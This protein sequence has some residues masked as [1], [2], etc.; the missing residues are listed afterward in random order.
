MAFII[1]ISVLVLIA[2][3]LGLPIATLLA[4][5]RAEREQTADH[6]A[7]DSRLRS[8]ERH[9]LKILARHSGGVRPGEKPDK[10][11]SPLAKE[12]QPET[13]QIVQSMLRQAKTN[14][15]IKIMSEG[16]S[17]LP[18]KESLKQPGLPK[19]QTAPKLSPEKKETVVQPG[20]DKPTI[21]PTA[22]ESKTKAV[23]P[24]KPVLVAKVVG[25]EEVCA[26][27]APPP[28]TASPIKPLPQRRQPVY[29]ASTPNVYQGPSDLEVRTKEVLQ[30]IWNWIVVGEEY[31]P[32]GVSMEYAIAKN[33]LLRIGA[34]IF[35]LGIGFFL[36]YSID[37]GWIG[38]EGRIALT[39]ITGL[40]MV[41]GGTFLL[42]GKKYDLFGQGLVGIG[43]AVLYFT[44]FAAMK[45]YEM[46]EQLPAFALMTLVTAVAC[47]I[48]VRF[49]TLLIALIG[50]IGGYATP[51]LLSTGVVDLTGLFT[52]LSILTAGVLAISYAKEW[53]LVRA[54]SLFGTWG[55]TLVALREA[56]PL[57]DAEFIQVIPF[58]VG[59]FVMFSTM[60]FLYNLI[61]QKESTLLEL[62]M[63]WGNAVT[64]FCIAYALFRIR[65][66]VPDSL[67][68]C[69]QFTFVTLGLALFYVVHIYYFLVK[70]VEDRVLLSSFF[71]I[72]S[73]ML[74][75]TV[76]ILISREWLAVSWAIQAL[77][78]LWVA[79][80]LDSRFLE[81]VA[82][83]L[84]TIVFC[85]FLG[86]LGRHFHPVTEKTALV[87][88]DFWMQLL[89]RLLTFGTMIGSF[90]GASWLLNH[91]QKSIESLRVQDENNWAMPMESRALSITMSVLCVCLGFVYLNFEF[92]RT[93]NYLD[94][95]LTAPAM[96]VLWIGLIG[97]LLM[98]YLHHKSDAL[99]VLLG[100][101]IVG[102]F[103]KFTFFDLMGWG[104]TKHFYYEA[105]SMKPAMI[106]LFDFGIII[107]MLAA[108]GRLL[109][110]SDSENG[111]QLSVISIVGAIGLLFTYTSLELN[112]ILYH[113]LPGSR[114]G[115]ISVLWSLYA[116]AF[117][118]IG[119]WK[120]VR[121]VRYAGLAL[122][123]IVTMKV[124]FVDLANAVK[125]YSI[126]FILLGIVLMCGSLVYMRCRQAF[127]I[128][129]EEEKK[130]KLTS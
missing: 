93:F 20:T 10:Q 5:L 39:T 13:E 107:A 66:G 46:I 70:K 51:I 65:F 33:W 97:F 124:L 32:E 125:A 9:A 75:I 23:P 68:C 88:H 21:I 108:V 89:E 76:P 29:S 113:C 83:V 120:N 80:K 86:D 90:F 115:G 52:Y 40:G 126:A 101:V 81:G 11:E 118:I 16:H 12:S 44:I 7:F 53:H 91:R 122:F 92:Y 73:F 114:M 43:V 45:Q 85:M 3:I 123:A 4:V 48:A 34:L 57:E 59:F 25:E 26:S 84:Y 31:R 128:E 49:N 42:G 74:T 72:A 27:D 50:V 117:I 54:V 35:V 15:G 17:K 116:L 67:A 24:Q 109:W 130:E 111:H 22:D 79:Q 129:E 78:M 102:L 87:P 41:T 77:V 38:P 19:Q 106:R 2:L 82:G 18:G 14:A 99:I 119:I 121:A 98:Q 104:I 105:C 37:Q 69:K 103:L 6:N 58:M 47:G 1:F 64:F 8:L 127:C 71:A 110:K 112:S 55:L 95:M 60:N 36:K 61:K 63:L 94:A 62:G 100:F 30:K 96:T 56:W 28:Q